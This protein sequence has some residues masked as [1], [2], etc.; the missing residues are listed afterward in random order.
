MTGISKAAM[1]RLKQYA[2]PCNIR[3]LEN[4][5]E[6]AVALEKT[7]T[8]LPDS[9]PEQIRDQ[10]AEALAAPPTGEGF[11]E[12]GFDLE[13]HVEDIQR[14]WMVRALRQA[15]GVKIK[16]AELCGMSFRSF[17]HYAKKYNLK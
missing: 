9:L 6:R 10:A 13:R 16:A 14:E 11:P 3:E 4:A 8:I 5:M 15:G 2:W 12:E 7:P 17:R 1:E